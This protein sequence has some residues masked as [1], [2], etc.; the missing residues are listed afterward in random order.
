MGCLGK[1]GCH[2]GGRDLPHFGRQCVAVGVVVC[3]SQRCLRIWLRCAP[4]G[5]WHAL[6]SSTPQC[7]VVV[8][9]FTHADGLAAA[10]QSPVPYTRDGVLLL[11]KDALY[12]GGQVPTALLWKDAHCSRFAIDTD[13]DGQVP[14]MQ[15]CAAH[16]H[17]H[18]LQCIACQL[19]QHLLLNGVCRL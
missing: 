2:L 9:C 18:P 17:T 6:L 15:V 19:L 11:H 16:T 8:N 12:E 1:G 13:P 3:C 10:Y 4:H 7:A 14:A 5:L